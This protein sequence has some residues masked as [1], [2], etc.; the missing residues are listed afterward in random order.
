MTKKKKAVK[1]KP[2]KPTKKRPLWMIGAKEFRTT[3]AKTPDGAL[4]VWKAVRQERDKDT[5]LR[6]RPAIIKCV[7]P[8]SALRTRIYDFHGSGIYSAKFRVNRAMPVAAL[9]LDEGGRFR[10][11]TKTV[12]TSSFYTGFKYQIGRWAKRRIRNPSSD[13]G[14]GLHFFFTKNKAARLA[15]SYYD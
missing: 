3:P 9:V 13:C 4:V 10:K 15:R 6:G 14:P 7:V 5:Y 8:K 11:T 1:R 12:F 2:K